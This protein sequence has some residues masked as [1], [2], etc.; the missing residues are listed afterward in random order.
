MCCDNYEMESAMEQKRKSAKNRRKNIIIGFDN[1]EEEVP[2]INMNGSLASNLIRETTFNDITS[3]K[4]TDNGAISSVRGGRHSTLKCDNDDT[5]DYSKDWH[6]LAEIMDRFFFW[7]FL[8][9]ILAISLLLFHPLTLEYY[10]T[11]GQ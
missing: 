11:T 7:T 10:R 9:V 1:I 5:V 6:R 4:D 8:L 3:R 2:I